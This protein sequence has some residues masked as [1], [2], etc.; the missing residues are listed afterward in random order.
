MAIAVS[1]QA[2]TEAHL[3][4]RRIL[5]CLDRSRVAEACVPH[6]LALARTF[7][8]TLTLVY[9]MS[10]N[11][12]RLGHTT[13]DALSW[14]ISRQ[15]ARGY[16]ERLA[17][18]MTQALGRAVDVRVEQGRPA[19]RIVDL[20]RELSV[21]LTVL[22]SCGEGA[23][24]YGRLGNTARRVLELAGGS[25]FVARASTTGAPALPPKHLLVPLDGSLRT[26][27]V[28][29]AAARIA[30][31]QGA[32]MLLVHV[33]EDPSPTAL[34]T[35]A[36]DLELSRSLAARLQSNA[37]SYLGRLREQLENDGLRARSLVARS[38]NPRQCLLE[39]A[40]REES[41]LIVLSAHGSTC[42]SARP[43]GTATSYLLTRSSAPLLVLQDLPESEL[44]RSLGAGASQAPPSLRSSHAP[45]NA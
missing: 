43:F 45:E 33:V 27:S 13:H 28:L 9:V 18:E 12:S 39:I 10:V 16:L 32:E 20:G 26:E 31:T 36:V 22:G 4:K 7:G 25:I 37:E 19:E 21:E 44:A 34:L 2:L 35:T 30:R 15:E 1:H 29:P 3:S 23:G 40:E 17:A 6:A 24:P 42:D 14:E 38:A 5:V 41:D 8:S 11:E